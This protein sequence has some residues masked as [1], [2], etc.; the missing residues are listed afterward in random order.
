MFVFVDV[1]ISKQHGEK[2]RRTNKDG[3]ILNLFVVLIMKIRTSAQ[4]FPI[5][6]YSLTTILKYF[7]YR[8]NDFIF[9]FTYQQI[10]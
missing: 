4:R 6:T 2:T 8:L 7:T 9:V 5:F 1:S 10:K 3:N